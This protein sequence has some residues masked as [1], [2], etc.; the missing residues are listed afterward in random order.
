[1]F[2]AT[3]ILAILVTLNWAAHD[4]TASEIDPVCLKT[5]GQGICST[6]YADRLNTCLEKML[7]PRRINWDKANQKFCLTSNAKV[8]LLDKIC[9]SS[10]AGAKNHTSAASEASTRSPTASP[11]TPS[12]TASSTASSTTS[13]TTSTTTSST[14]SSTTS[15]VRSLQAAT[16]S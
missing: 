4:V 16:V 12:S 8:C 9:K 2:R 15:Q 10:S 13:S 1:M 3:G 11:M 7:D 5:L 6:F 14:T